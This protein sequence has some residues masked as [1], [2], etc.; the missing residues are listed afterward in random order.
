MARAGEERGLSG[1]RLRS[2]GREVE[3]EKEI[4]MGDKASNVLKV[5]KYELMI[6]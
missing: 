5:C 1:W 2:R 6:K 3:L 4:G